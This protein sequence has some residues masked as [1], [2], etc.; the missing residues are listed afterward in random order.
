MRGCMLWISDCVTSWS[1]V[2]DAYCRSTAVHDHT[3][4][5]ST[6]KIGIVVD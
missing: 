4:V 2:F 5:T 6:V 3:M 1:R